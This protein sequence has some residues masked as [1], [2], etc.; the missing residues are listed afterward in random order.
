MP[1]GAA[2]AAAGSPE[3]AA[4]FGLPTI[5]PA[6]PSPHGLV[7]A[8]ADWVAAPGPLVPLYLRRPDAKTLAERGL[9]VSAS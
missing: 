9:G 5:G 7:E 1:F 4:L 6:Y 3:H 8:V 2:A